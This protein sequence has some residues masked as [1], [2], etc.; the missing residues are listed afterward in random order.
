MAA[1]ELF[2]TFKADEMSVDQCVFYASVPKEAD[3]A[4]ACA[5][6]CFPEPFPI[7]LSRTFISA[8][9]ARVWSGASKIAR[10]LSVLRKVLLEDRA[11]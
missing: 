11:E 1:A 9:A 4:I 5:F 10:F 2:V 7:S 3:D 8:P 6:N